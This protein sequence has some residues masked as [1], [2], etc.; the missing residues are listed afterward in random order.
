MIQ[1]PSICH[2]CQ[3]LSWIAYQHHPSL[4]ICIMVD[5]VS[6]VF[7]TVWPN[8]NIRVALWYS[9]IIIISWGRWSGPR[10]NIKMP[11]YQYRKSYCGDKTVVRSS[12]LHNGISYT[13]KTRSLYWIRAQVITESFCLSLLLWLTFSFWL[14]F[15]NKYMYHF[16][17]GLGWEL[18][19]TWH[20][21]IFIYLYAD[22]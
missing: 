9:F 6:L 14:E 15:D 2:L 12:Y 17:Q 13:G 10:F 3:D 11:S 16:N 4:N 8:S 18:I 5:H 21:I 19:S 7:M 22:T 1:E 20:L